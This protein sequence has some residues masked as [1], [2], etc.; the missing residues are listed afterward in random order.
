MTAL[1]LPRRFRNQPTG[2]VSLRDDL[3]V[4]SN[5][6][7]IASD[8]IYGADGKIITYSATKGTYFPPG[9]GPG[10]KFLGNGVTNT[11]VNC[12]T[13]Q[14]P[15][16]VGDSFTLI[17]FGRL[18]ESKTALTPVI[19]YN[20]YSNLSAGDG[21]NA[22]FCF[23]ARYDGESQITAKVT[24]PTAY[25]VGKDVCYV[26]TSRPGTQELWRDGALVATGS[27]SAVLVSAAGNTNIFSWPSFY[28]AGALQRALTSGEAK[29]IS[30]FPYSV[31]KPRKS[32]LYFGGGAAG[33]TGTLAAT[34][35]DSDTASISGDVLVKGVLAATE[36]GADS[37]ALAGKVSIE[38]ALSA[39]ESGADTAALA[40]DVLVKGALSAAESGSDTASIA[41]DVLIKGALAASESGGDVAS[42][43]GYIE[44]LDIIGS[45]AAAESGADTASISGKVYLAGVLSAV[46]GGLDTFAA[47]GDILV[48]G[49]L[50][51]S[52]SGSDTALFLGA[53]VAGEL[54][55]TLAAGEFGSDSAV[56]L[57][58]ANRWLQS[59]GTA[60]A[61]TQTTTATN[62][63]TE[64]LST[65]TNWVR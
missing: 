61:W 27:S 40:G 34:E 60:G 49:A 51:A 31:V 24:D 18:D 53:G 1:I 35:S 65:S 45:L 25:T 9:Y 15:I 12:Y 23:A 19:Q 13:W 28:L 21:T 56:F 14:K 47:S 57:G 37:A 16:A 50:A 39:S 5:S 54:F 41:G 29:E 43:A 2:P 10:G 46:E 4:Y 36:S 32:V 3:L 11:S 55:G 30:Q 44:A 58:S 17:Y 7:I 8:D 22:K 42:I 64:G 33:I 38:G 20:N 59:G 63:W 6:F 52:E 62:V 26:F 48:K